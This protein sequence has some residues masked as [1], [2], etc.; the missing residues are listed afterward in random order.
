[1]ALV[2]VKTFEAASRLVLETQVNAFLATLAPIDALD[3]RIIYFRQSGT[4]LVWFGYVT[5]FIP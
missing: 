1:M 5:Y 2:Q 3:L 4:T